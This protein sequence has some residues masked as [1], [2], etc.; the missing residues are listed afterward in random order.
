MRGRV[1]RERIHTEC[2]VHKKAAYRYRLE[3][4]VRWQRWVTYMMFC[5]SLPVGFV[6]SMQKPSIANLFCS[7]TSSSIIPLNRI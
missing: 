3:E 7:V 2:S 6:P 4:P 1:D 5:S